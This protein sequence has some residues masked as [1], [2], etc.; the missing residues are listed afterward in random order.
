MQNEVLSIY[1]V[2]PVDNNEI[3][4]YNIGNPNLKFRVGEKEI[5][6]KTFST[7]VFNLFFFFLVLSYYMCGLKCPRKTIFHEGKCIL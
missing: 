6:I 4:I 7:V 2:V 5:S 1:F 3:Q